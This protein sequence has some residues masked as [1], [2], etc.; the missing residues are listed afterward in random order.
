MTDTTASNEPEKTEA[1]EDLEISNTPDPMIAQAR[2]RSEKDT[3][4]RRSFAA[5]QVI[6]ARVLFGVILLLIVGYATTAIKLLGIL[7]EDPRTIITKTFD[8][9]SGFD[10]FLVGDLLLTP[11]QR[12]ENLGVVRQRSSES[13]SDNTLEF[14]SA[15]SKNS[16]PD[17]YRSLIKPTVDPALIE[18]TSVGDLPIIS[19]DGRSP[20]ITYA[21][22]F[23][24]ALDTSEL[25]ILVHG[26]GISETLALAAL[27]LKPEVSLAFS[28]Y[29][30]KLQDL[31][32]EARK[33]GHE[34][35]LELP[36]EPMD[37]PMLDPGPYALRKSYSTEKNIT[38]FEWILSRTS[39]YVGLINYQGDAL[40][41]NSSFVSTFLPL[42]SRRGLMFIE[43]GDHGGHVRKEIEKNGDYY[44]SF[45]IQIGIDDDEF[46]LEE[47]LNKALV[48]SKEKGRVTI[49]VE[50]FP[51][52]LMKIA[53][54]IN[55]LSGSEFTLTPISSQ[56][57]LH[58]ARK[59]GLTG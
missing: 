57:Q 21:R 35:F 40:L 14:L 11:D 25:S 17:V 8:T 44:T 51:L 23:N 24:E 9:R 54:W 6:L 39:G 28:P 20:L 34:I 59:L 1:L 31:S 19:N 22:P 56:A 38:Q 27:Q 52:L 43:N 58:E 13:A 15:L 26:L 5:R 3:V 36:M 53:L 50:P 49:S 41:R 55:E 37:Y 42:I 48:I 46:S 18:T 12:I 33:A 45:D 16:P 4:K 47:K 2:K 10:N 7:S 32:I 30:V 29:T